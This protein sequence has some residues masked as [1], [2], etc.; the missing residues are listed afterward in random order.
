[1]PS[2]LCC[3]RQPKIRG[4]PCYH[5]QET[6]R[7]DSDDDHRDPVNDTLFPNHR[8]IATE[9]LHP[10]AMTENGGP[11]RL[12]GLIVGCNEEPAGG[13]CEAKNVE[14]IIG[15]EL[16]TSSF[17]GTAYWLEAPL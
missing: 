14:E 6:L 16:E 15:D 9:G 8:G 3:G 2:G 11:L 5:A 4:G 1:M 13:W 7:S 10:V 12:R 17:R